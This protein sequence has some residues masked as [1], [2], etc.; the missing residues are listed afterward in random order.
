MITKLALTMILTDRNFNTAFYD[1]AGGGDPVLYQH[2]FFQ[3]TI[4]YTIPLGLSKFNFVT[5]YALYTK[6]FPNAE[7]PS[8]SFLEWLVGFAEGDGSFT[9]NSRETAVFVI[10]QSTVD[11]KILYYIQQILGFGRV[12]KQGPTTS[13]FVVKDIASITLL[14]ALFNGNL[15]FPLK[16]VSFARF[17][18]AFNCRSKATNVTLI[19][20]LIIPSANDYWLCGITDAKGNFNCSLLGNSTAYRFRFLLAQLGNINLPV[21]THLTTIIGGVVTPHSVE[22]VYQLIVNGARNII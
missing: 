4:L 17:L 5:F 9:V 6:R 22:G 3:T 14:I 19:S 11:I 12:I 16:Q 21:L 10:T 15:V 1:P 8:Q 13:R 7:A 20:S 2:L 18:N